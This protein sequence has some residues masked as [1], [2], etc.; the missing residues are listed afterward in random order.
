MVAKSFEGTLKWNNES[1]QIDEL[2]S[3]IPNATK[4][5]ITGLLMQKDSRSKFYFEISRQNLHVLLLTSLFSEKLFFFLVYLQKIKSA[6]KYARKMTSF[7]RHCSNLQPT[8]FQML[9]CASSFLIPRLVQT[10]HIK[11]HTCDHM[12]A[13]QLSS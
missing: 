1:A 13:D 3:E 12:K 4:F 5:T 11:M 2:C 9:L 10:L 6:I 8:Q 7:L